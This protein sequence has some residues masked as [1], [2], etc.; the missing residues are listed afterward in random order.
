[1]RIVVP[2]FFDP[3]ERRLWTD[4]G[5]EELLFNVV[6]TALRI[7]SVTEVLVCS[8]EQSV[9]EKA[10]A[11]GCAVRRL[12]GPV[13]TDGPF[14][15]GF[16][17]LL[18]DA[19]LFHAGTRSLGLVN[20]RYPL[21]SPEHLEQCLSRH[22]EDAGKPVVSVRRPVFHPC[23]LVSYWRLA[24]A[25]GDGVSYGGDDVKDAVQL[26]GKT[27]FLSRASSVATVG[28]GSRRDA[29]AVEAS[30]GFGGCLP[31]ASREPYA[32]WENVVGGDVQAVIHMPGTR[33]WEAPQAGNLSPVNR[34]TGEKIR[35]R[36]QYPEV[37][38][39]S[40][41]VFVVGEGGGA[42]LL[43]EIL[44]GRVRGVVLPAK[45]AHCVRNDIDLLKL[46]LSSTEPAA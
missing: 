10:K 2:V 16:E 11:H 44:A 19:S 18:D 14:P 31:T 38:V 26:S 5:P 41:A 28:D 45:E 9:L 46:D 24:G 8:P 40:G 43:H 17:E 42:R 21:L 32:V 3:G 13:E 39:P 36:Q 37:Y 25:G 22:R 35:G 7:S 27:M 6:R 29:G 15:P 20:F 4:S 30:S 23:R 34:V 12:D 1:M 33:L